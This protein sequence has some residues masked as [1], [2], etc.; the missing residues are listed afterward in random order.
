[1]Q[2]KVGSPAEIRHRAKPIKVRKT[3]LTPRLLRKQWP[4]RPTNW[5][6]KEVTD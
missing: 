1:M 2:T 4:Q 3:P 6:Q 5:A